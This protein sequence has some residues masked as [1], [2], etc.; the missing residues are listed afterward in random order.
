MYIPDLLLR[1]ASGYVLAETYMAS[2]SW[3][4][5]SAIRGSLSRK[6]KKTD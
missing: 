6:G 2:T 3:L 4:S 1:P 5:K